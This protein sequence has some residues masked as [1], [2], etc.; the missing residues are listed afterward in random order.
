MKHTPGPWIV[1]F[2]RLGEG[3]FPYHWIE[4]TNVFSCVCNLP[5][6][7]THPENEANAR[8][9]AAAPD[10][11]DA[12]E[13]AYCKLLDLGQWEGRMSCEGQNILCKL[14]DSIA[15]AKGR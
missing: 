2:E 15:K 13:L 7:N 1:K 4:S 6:G 14:R 12:C 11:L 9:I 8:L 10:L 3:Q 5:S